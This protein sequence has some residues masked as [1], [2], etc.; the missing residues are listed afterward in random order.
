MSGRWITGWNQ[1]GL[2][3]V[4]AL[5]VV[6]VVST[7]Q[8]VRPPPIEAPSDQVDAVVRYERR[9][10]ALRDAALARGLKGT[11]GYFGS[12]PGGDDYFHA[13]FALAPLV[14]DVNAAPY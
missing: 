5:A 8:K 1:G 9:L 11:V 7:A 10:A 6:N 13:Q 14:L 12:L 4:A 3:A 2:L